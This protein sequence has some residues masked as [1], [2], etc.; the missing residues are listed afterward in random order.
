MFELRVAI[1]ASSDIIGNSK[2]LAYAYDTQLRH[3]GYRGRV[4]LPITFNALLSVPCAHCIFS[5]RMA[6]AA[7][8]TECASGEAPSRIP[9]SSIA[10]AELGLNTYIQTIGDNRRLNSPACDKDRTAASFRIA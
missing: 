1:H 4:R 7:K 6:A 9:S 3:W 10:L 5:P 2:R 8:S